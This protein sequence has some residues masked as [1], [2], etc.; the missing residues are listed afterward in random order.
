MSLTKCLV[1][2]DL[3]ADMEE[4]V[5]I[6][7][8][9]LAGTLCQTQNAVDYMTCCICESNFEMAHSFLIHFIFVNRNRQMPKQAI[10]TDLQ[11]F[12]LSETHRC[13]I[14]PM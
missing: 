1:M 11:P 13:A 3:V 12:H 6:W 7:I 2:E 5:K 10:I 4:L 14:V 8:I 9:L